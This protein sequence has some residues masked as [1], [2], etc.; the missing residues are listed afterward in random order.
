MN[1]PDRL[2]E[3]LTD[4][5]GL[6]LQTPVADL[7]QQA[8]AGWDSVAMVQLIGD[9]QSAFAIDFELDEIEHL[10]SYNEIREALARKGVSLA[11]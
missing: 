3:L 1:K 4:F 5:F 2:Q 11:S 10:R 6:P 9:L 7:K 8:I